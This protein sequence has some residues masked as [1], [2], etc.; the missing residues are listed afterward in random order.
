M[1]TSIHSIRLKLAAAS[2]AV[3]LAAC[4]G[5]GSSAPPPTGGLT[6]DPGDG[7]V[8]VSW[9]ATSGVDYWLGWL[10]ASS[11]SLEI[12][13]PHTWVLNVSSPYVLKGL[14][15]GTTYA[16]SVNGRT[17]GGAGG[18]ATPSMATAP[19]P[20]GFT[21]S[22]GTPTTLGSTA[23]RSLAY[24]TAADT[25]IDYVAVGDGSAVYKGTDGINWTAVSTSG[26]PGSTFNFRAATYTLSKFIAAGSGG[27]IFY[28]TD[29]ATWTAATSNISNAINVNALAS[30]GTTVVAVGDAGTIRYSTD[31]ATWTAAASV[32]TSNTLNG[33]TYAASGLWIAVGANGT[34]LTSSDG[35]SWTAQTSNTTANLTS[36]A[37]QVT[38]VYTYVAVGDA[39]TVLKSTDGSTWT[40]ATV[41]PAANLTAVVVPSTNSQFLAVGT[42]GAVFTSADAVT[43]IDRSSSSS[44]TP[45][46]CAAGH[47]WLGLISAQVQYVAL[48][49]D[50]AN[51][52]SH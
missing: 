10:A 4:G 42:G 20:G 52:N 51:C 46:T 35:S 38:T 18:A 33:V 26:L 23:M 31:G 8:T 25:S 24:G 21:W 39:G 44:T 49:S 1:F 5:G 2:A 17:D 34:L 15:N 11:V 22:A 28:S 36:V 16:F 29:M 27:Q 37:T 45:S 48:A 14:T 40:S 19:R 41:S 32:P 3:M 47:D 43:W 30:N 13:M 12:G 9:T 6:L 7:Q 50:G